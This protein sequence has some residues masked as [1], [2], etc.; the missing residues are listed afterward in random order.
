MPQRRGQLDNRK[1]FLLESQ[2]LRQKRK[3]HAAEVSLRRLQLQKNK[4]EHSLRAAGL[5]ASL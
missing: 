1:D 5:V 4:H 2:T 3:A